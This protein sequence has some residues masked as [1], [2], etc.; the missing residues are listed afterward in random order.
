MK[1]SPLKMLSVEDQDSF[2]DYCSGADVYSLIYFT[3]RDDFITK[4]LHND[5]NLI[6]LGFNENA[7][8]AL[9]TRLLLELTGDLSAVTG[10]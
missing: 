2:V 9:E 6:L 1:S 10:L 5:N 4:F 3:A 7:I 8:S